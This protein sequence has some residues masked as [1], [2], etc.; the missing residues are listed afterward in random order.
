MKRSTKIQLRAESLSES[1][2]DGDAEGIARFGIY[3]NEVGDLAS[4]VEELTAST[5]VADMVDAYI[6]STAGQSVLY[7]WAKDIA[8]DEQFSLEEEQAEME[9]SWRAA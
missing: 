7:A 4:A 3:L 6:Q 1:I 5:T 9:A 8:E 2:H